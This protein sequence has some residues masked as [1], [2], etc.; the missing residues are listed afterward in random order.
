M[1]EIQDRILV[2]LYPQSIVINEVVIKAPKIRGQGDTVTYFVNQFSSDRDKTIGDVLRKMP[3]INVDTKGKITYNGKEINK[4]YIE[5]QDL[6]EGKY[7]IATN[8][9]PQQEVGTVEVYEDHQPI[10]ALEGLFFS[11]Q[12]AINIKLKEG[13]KAHWITTLDLESGLPL[14]LWL[15]LIHISEPTRP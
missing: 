11:D 14:P 13:A 1:T 7:G 3:G 8:G 6:L 4:F 2:K 10:K 12:A 5:G 9:I 15:S